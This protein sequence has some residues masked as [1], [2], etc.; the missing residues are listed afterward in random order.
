[1]RLR[2]A[3]LGDVRARSAPGIRVGLPT[4]GRA[5]Q[6]RIRRAPL[7]PTNRTRAEGAVARRPA[8]R[9]GPGGAGLEG[10]A[11]RRPARLADPAALLPCSPRARAACALRR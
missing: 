5:R 7:R 11:A 6:C 2:R 8:A 10:A 3:T 1:G 9:V 4:A